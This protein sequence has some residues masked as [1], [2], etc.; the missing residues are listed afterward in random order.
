MKNALRF[1]LL[2]I[3]L[4]S[5]LTLAQETIVMQD[6]LLGSTI[7]VQYGGTI[8]PD[9]Y[10]PGIGF[11]HI[12]FD[13]PSQV[14]NGYME[15][16][17]KGFADA[18]I[19]DPNGGA[20]ADNA[21]FGMY[22][23][24]GSAEPIR[25]FNNFKYNYFRWNF[26][27]RQNRDV[28]KAVLDCANPE[29]GNLTSTQAW[30]A[31]GASDNCA[32]K[33][34]WYTEPNG[35]FFP[36]NA[37]TWH[38]V[39]VIWNNKSFR[40]TIDGTTVWGPVSGP[41]DYAP[42]DFKIWLG[43]AP[44]YD[45]KYGNWVPGTTYRNFKV[46]SYGTVQNSA[47]RI[48]S[49]P[50]TAGIVGQLYQYDVDATGNPSATYSLVTKPTGMTINSVN[51]LIQ[52]TPTTTGAFNVQVKAANGVSPDATQSFVINVANPQNIAPTI[53]STAV[54][55]ATVG[56]LYQYDVNASGNPSPTF[57]LVTFP[58]GMTINQTSGLIQWTP[59][60]TGAFNVQV[61]AANGVNPDATQ[62]FVIN[63]AHAQ[64]IAP[65]I[66]STAITNATVGLLYQYDVNATGNPSPTFSLTTFPAGMTINQTHGLIQWTPT[67]AGNFNVTVKAANGVS[68]DATQSFVINVTAPLPCP[69]GLLS[70]WKL[71]E[72]GV[73]ATYDDYI[74][75]NNATTTDAPTPSTGRVNGAQNFNGISDRLSAARI[76]AYDFSQ[77]TSFT[78]ELWLNHPAVSYT[79]EEVVLERRSGKVAI[80]LRFNS[81]RISFLARNASSQLFQVTGT[82]NLFDGRWHHVVGV[83]DAAANL[84]RI[85][86]DGVLQNSVAAAYTSGFASTGGG[87]TIGWRNTPGDESYFRGAIDE[88]AIYNVA[89]DGATILQ[90]YNNGL[91]NMGYC[92]STMA[93]LS[94]NQDE[95]FAEVGDLVSGQT[96][97]LSWQS[98]TTLKEGK[99]EVERSDA[100]SSEWL[101]VGEID[102]L[103]TNESKSFN[104]IDNPNASG[105]FN[106]RIKYSNGGSEVYSNQ[107]ETEVL[108]TEYVLSQNYPNPFNP[109]T[110][111]RF[112]V[113]VVSKVTLQVYNQ[114][115][116][117]VAQPVD[118]VYEAG[119]YEIEMN[120]SGLA[121]GV[122]FYK[123]SAGGFTDIKKMML[124][125]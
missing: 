41:N 97:R 72:T 1:F 19:Q 85:Y 86:V 40:V 79:R 70:Y 81:N 96:I 21:F 69:Q 30:H 23:G 27:W 49:T 121:S 98:L 59:T 99:F 34:E 89:L 39:K 123:L 9:G 38:T 61:K 51:G 73:V 119:N 3:L 63:V 77:S 103:N 25:Y 28:V 56:Q 80:N 111:I 68:P 125:K 15:F 94:L 46:V 48:I 113:P 110:K 57:S 91:Q 50:I 122:Y 26:H 95:V 4:V 12:L 44:G 71:D 16:Q 20:D 43:A 47:P 117:I 45:D 37:N 36:F 101:K 29:P 17:V 74:G 8:T 83:R 10:K 11:N 7:G 53:T 104:I 5:N 75:T 107:I 18:L 112:A 67:A 55:N 13:V 78:F 82:S 2:T 93:K 42:I 100:A 87:V 60:T 31:C 108:P 115:G 109:S 90:H 35:T 102:L 22:D 52:W 54:T 88:V 33:R 62:S 6:N 14:V 64:N 105:K 124:T 118:N 116:E 24:R 120:M 106:Y 32:D 84:L 66:T 76:P 58:A 65:A 114:L 92:Q